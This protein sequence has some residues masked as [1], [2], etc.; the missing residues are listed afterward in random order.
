M[1]TEEDDWLPRFLAE[2][3]ALSEAERDAAIAALPPE[4][5][6]ALLALDDA[7]AATLG[8]D[9]MKALDSGHGGLERLYEVADPWEL[10][11]VINLAVREQPAIVVDA[12]FAAVVAHRGWGENQPPAMASLREQ[13]IWHVHDEVSRARE[14]IRRGDDAAG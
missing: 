6:G 8:A 4:R 11:G 3:A 7:R 10:L 2:F 1:S 12:L 5:Q 13:W 14:E 9:P